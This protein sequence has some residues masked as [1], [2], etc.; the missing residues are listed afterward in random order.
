MDIIRAA[1]G[2]EE[3]NYLGFSYGTKLGM[4]YAEHYPETVGRFVLDGM[5]DTSVDSHELELAQARGFESALEAMPHGA[6][7][8]RTARWRGS[9]R[10]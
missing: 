10:M 8:R 2:E 1:L 4:S 3:L 5:M 6:W 9:L 7:S